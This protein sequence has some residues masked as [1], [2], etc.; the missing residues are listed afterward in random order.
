M[1]D[2][3]GASVN[4]WGLANW[5]GVFYAGIAQHGYANERTFSFFPLYPLLL[6]FISE[7]ILAYVLPF[8]SVESRIVFAGLGVSIVATAVA[9]VALYRMT[10]E[11]SHDERFASLTA[12]LFIMNPAQIFHAVVYTEALFSALSFSGMYFIMKRTP[13]AL[14]W[15]TILFA[16]SSAARP[17]GVVNAGFPVYL[18]A[19]EVL[20]R[21]IKIWSSVFYFVCASL[22]CV[23]F[24]AYMVYIRHLL[25]SIVPFEPSCQT[26]GVMSAYFSVQ[27][28]FWHLG[29]MNFYTLENIPFLLIAAPLILVSF[30]LLLPYIRTR[31]RDILSLSIM[32]HHKYTRQGPHFLTECNEVFPF[33]VHYAVLFLYGLCFMHVHVLV[34]LL[35]SASPFLYWFVAHI[36][37]KRP[38]LLAKLS[39]DWFVLYSVLG[40]VLFPSFFPWT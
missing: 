7:Y 16:F 27:S 40:L 22:V 39:L 4:S 8:V 5:D 38:A 6:H 9:V 3:S 25:C 28:R 18:A 26:W 17:N 33:V 15:S 35:C 12:L 34:R 37:S 20:S 32:E 21:R 11:L 19:S 13:S 24:V 30:I 14:V 1:Y 36:A 29:F 31:S 2:S 23:P 10:L